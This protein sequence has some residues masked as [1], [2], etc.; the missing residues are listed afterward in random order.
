MPN[1]AATE[2]LR[3]LWDRGF[4]RVSLFKVVRPFVYDRFH[5]YG[6]GSL[7]LVYKAVL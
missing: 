3:A 7:P 6:D 4:C 2:V 1:A 5:W